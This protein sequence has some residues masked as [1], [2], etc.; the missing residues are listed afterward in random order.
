LKKLNI[1]I[2]SNILPYPLNNGGAQA[3]FHIIDNLRQ[4]VDISML[5]IIHKNMNTVDNLEKLKLIWPDVKFI[6]YYSNWRDYEFTTIV[7]KFKLKIQS[8]FGLKS[9]F[10]SIG[11]MSGD[12]FTNNFLTFVKNNVDQ[13]KYDIIQ[14]EFYPF[15]GLIYSL[16]SDAKKIFIQHEINFVKNK[17]FL[18]MYT[19]NV[20]EQYLF[21]R[22]KLIEIATMNEYDAVIALTEVDRLKLVESGVVTA[23]Y[24]SPGGIK[25]KNIE[26]FNFNF[27]NKIVFLGGYQHY[28]NVDA[29]EW[30]LSE[31]WEKILSGNPILEFHI[32]G[33]W[34]ENIQKKYIKK[35][36]KIF[37]NGFVPNLSDILD[38]SIVVVPL[39]IGSGM[40]MKIIEAVNYGCPVITTSI[41]VEGLDF[42]DGIDCVITDE[43]NRFA[44]EVVE[45]SLNSIKQ[46]EYIKN[47][48]DCFI[49]NYSI[50][51]LSQKRFSI[52]NSLFN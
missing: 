33:I 50:D 36:P 15:M 51:K 1:L 11:E 39:R 52:Y 7:N 29:V 10:S 14:T 35:Y 45:L 8:V 25:F 32:V 18:D 2:I 37:F 43:P 19:T 27:N 30:Y 5:V 22:N 31:I 46:S 28:P 16:E 6:P 24:S 49:R 3:Q 17:I 4:I 12:F 42:I 47:S 26:N 48:K 23:V 9:G 21:K 38:N 13:I 20:F 44:L 34:P 41:G 40:R